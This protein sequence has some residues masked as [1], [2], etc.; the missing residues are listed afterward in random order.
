MDTVDTSRKQTS[1]K[2]DCGACR[3]QF[4]YK[5]EFCDHCTTCQGR[6]HEKDH[7]DRFEGT[8]TY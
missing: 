8:F 4:C 2:K 3:C 1:V 5:S 6:S 7:C